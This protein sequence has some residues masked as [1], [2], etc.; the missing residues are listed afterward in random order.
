MPL[1]DMTWHDQSNEHAKIESP[2]MI[3]KITD[4]IYQ[5]SPYCRSFFLY[6]SSNLFFWFAIWKAVLTNI[7]AANGTLARCTSF[8]WISCDVYEFSKLQN[9]STL[10]NCYK[11]YCHDSNCSQNW[12]NNI[13]PPLLPYMDNDIIDSCEHILVEIREKK[14]YIILC[15]S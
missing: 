9:P 6:A 5:L 4:E 12:Q 7:K 3:M 8:K 1:H 10:P 13:S 14:K 2:I 15:H 11:L